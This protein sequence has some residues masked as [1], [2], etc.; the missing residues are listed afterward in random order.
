MK[1]S[2]LLARHARG[3]RPAHAVASSPLSRESGR[4]LFLQCQTVRHAGA[5]GAMRVASPV[6]LVRAPLD[7]NAGS[8][9]GSGTFHSHVLREISAM[10]RLMSFCTAR[11]AHA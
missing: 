1:V 2:S 6:S 5:S 11:R 9:P 7:S 10:T 4:G 3:V 8:H